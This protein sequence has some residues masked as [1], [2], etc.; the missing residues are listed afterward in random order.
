M[1]VLMFLI[2]LTKY[3]TSFYHA[4]LH[5][6]FTISSIIETKEPSGLE[7]TVKDKEKGQES[8]SIIL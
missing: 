3:A 6:H 8:L 4:C 1:S 5:F 7:H 2:Y